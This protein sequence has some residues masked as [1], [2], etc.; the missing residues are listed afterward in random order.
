[1]NI[2]YCD[3]IQKVL[4]VAKIAG[5][6]VADIYRRK[7]YRIQSKSDNSP[8]TEADLLSHH[9]IQEGL[10]SID[11][12]L[13]MISEEG[14]EVPFQVRSLWPRYWLVDPLDGTQEFIQ[15]RS[16][17]TIN[18]ALIENHVPVL[19]VV[20]VPMLNHYYWST[21]GQAAYFQ[22]GTRDPLIIQANCKVQFP[23]RL[24]VSRRASQDSNWISLLERLEKY[25]IMYCGSALKICWVAQGLADLYP[26]FGAT[27]EWDT[28][29]GQ[30]I[31]ESAGG[32]LVDLSGQSLMYNNRPTL[33]NPSFCA[34]SCVN[35]LPYVVDNSV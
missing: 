32:K 3:L 34:M 5:E 13:P 28:A 30:C 6:A 12:S 17:F 22:E 8:V 29:A 23:I 20:A 9:L 27:G 26:R 2:N 21:K 31:L 1:M 16:E 14:Q 35:L 4:A 15:G 11:S 33:I 19:G 25:E 24:V 18:I 7:D 10:S